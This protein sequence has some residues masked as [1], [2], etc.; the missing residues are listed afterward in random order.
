MISLEAITYIERMLQSRGISDY[1]CDVFTLVCDPNKK[2][3][4]T[5]AFEGYC[6]LLS[7]D[8]PLGTVIASETSV[9]NIDQNWETKNITKVQEFSG[10]IALHLPEA[11][12]LSQVEFFR[13]IPRR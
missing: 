7:H 5:P 2:D 3:F 13:A 9:L 1:Y 12:V 6:F 8:M 4:Y 11:G 10:Q